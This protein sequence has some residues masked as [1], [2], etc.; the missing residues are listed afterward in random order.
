[1]RTVAAASVI[2]YSTSAAVRLGLIGAAAPRRQAANIPTT[3]TAVLG[4]LICYD[5]TR[6]PRRRHAGL[7]WR[8]TA[9]A[10]A[11]LSGSGVSSAGAGACGAPRRVDR[12]EM[13]KS[14]DGS[15]VRTGSAGNNLRLCDGSTWSSGSKNPYLFVPGTES[16]SDSARIYSVEMDLADERQ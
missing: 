7:P 14:P 10:N 15:L 2:W 11:V 9:S 4:S 12:A 5:V 8:R 3:S 16:G 13:R 1:M 6:V